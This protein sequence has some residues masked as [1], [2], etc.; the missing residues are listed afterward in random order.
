MQQGKNIESTTLEELF[1]ED[2][3][4]NIPILL[5]IV[6]EDIFW[7][8]GHDDTEEN[9]LIGQ[10]N[11]HL[12]LINNNIPV[13][14]EK[15][16]YLPSKF[17]FEQPQEDGHKVGNTSITISAID[18][19]IIEIIRSIES[20]PRAMVI[21]AFQKLDNTKIVFS[22]I[23]HYTFEMSNANWDGVT[24]KWDLTFDPAM[25]RNIPVDKA[26]ATRCPSAYEQNS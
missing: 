3:S 18:Q 5:D 7:G 12:R 16:K 14:Y 24:A 8:E 23:Y 10:T 22:K 4:G 13:I 6:H 2:I 20:K 25:S 9:D 21:A 17:T 26:T 1:S 15:K 19:R 11:G